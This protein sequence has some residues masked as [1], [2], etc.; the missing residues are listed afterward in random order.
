MVNKER[1][2]AGRQV[3][4]WVGGWLTQDGLALLRNQV[5]DVREDATHLA[6]MMLGDAQAGKASGS[7]VYTGGFSDCWN[8]SDSSFLHL[9]KKLHTFRNSLP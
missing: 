5:I 7:V 9:S 3:G 1:P 6:G 8:A 4:G 2:G